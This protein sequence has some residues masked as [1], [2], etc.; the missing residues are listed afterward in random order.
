M[1]WNNDSILGK[2]LLHISLHF[3]VPALLVALFYRKQ[4]K[5]SYFI[6][7]STMLVDFDHLI[8]IPIYDPTRCSIGFHPLHTAFPM[9]IYFVLSIYPKTRLIGL[10]LII[11]MLLDSLDCYVTNGVWFTL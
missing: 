6:L 5:L 3:I 4:W 8:A 1:I 2:A 11:H 10:G 7:M 9:M